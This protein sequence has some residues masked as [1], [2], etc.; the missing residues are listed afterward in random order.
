M[1]I[2]G[3]SGHTKVIVNCLRAQNKRILAF[4][5][6]DP[7]KKLFLEYPVLNEYDPLYYHDEKLIIGIGD[8]KIRKK[9][10]QFIKHP[11]GQTIHPTAQVA[12][13]SRV[14]EGTVVFHNSVIQT[15]TTIGKHS[16]IN[17]TA[18]VDHDCTIENYVH[19][20]PNTTICG[21]ISIG[22]GTLVGAGTVIV[23]NIKIGRWC[24]ISAGSVVTKDI[25]DFSLIAGNPARIIKKLKVH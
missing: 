21:G 17:T 18:S 15:G 20:A 12:E 11:F 25:P 13:E 1:L 23:P 4:F 24:I 8:N 6:D 7:D 14:E 19:I 10:S 9:V 2:Y 16:I 22:E 5:D 3:A